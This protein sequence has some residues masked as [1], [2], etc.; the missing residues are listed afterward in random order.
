MA[1]L[2]LLIYMTINKHIAVEKR[3]YIN[4]AKKEE[5][6]GPEKGYEQ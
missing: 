6:M 4:L 1:G 3:E 2:F 5:K